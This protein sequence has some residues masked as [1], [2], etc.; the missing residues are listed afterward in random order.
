[1]NPRLDLLHPYPF[2][3]LRRLFAGIKP[4][5]SGYEIN[6]GIGEPQHPTPAV[7]TDALQRAMPLL[8][9]YPPTAGTPELRATIA[10]W[11]G[12]RYAVTV[13][14]REVLPVSGSREALYAF[15]QA[16]LDPADPGVVLLPNPFYQ[17]YEGAA[18]MVGAEPF[19]VPTPEGNGYLPDWSA[20][21]EEVWL[22]VKLVYVCSPGNPTGAVLGLEDWNELFAYADRYGFT[23][24]ADECYSEIYNEEPPVGALEAAKAYGRSHERLVVFNSLSKRSSAPGL[25]SGFVAGDPTILEK[26][27]LY[28]TYQGCAPSLVVQAASVAAWNDESHV[29]E[30]RAKYRSK[31]EATSRFFDYSGFPLSA[32]VPAGGFFYWAKVED[33]DDENFAKTLYSAYGLT[34]LP[35][36]Y[37]GRDAGTGNP[38]K[39]YVRIALVPELSA[40]ESVFQHIGHLYDEIREGHWP[41]DPSQ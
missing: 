10:E 4:F 37:L 29:E 12:R 3:R 23:I 36:T 25:R 26:F 16:V 33:G 28:R 30:N 9:K 19:Y 35:G 31:Y 1:M 40:C 24:A 15:A 6:L 2:E 18:L 32:T 34:V 17:I 14:E 27:L 7:I 13:E 5:Y 41:R 21:P 22:R 20:V 11:L 8:G 39:G 38:G